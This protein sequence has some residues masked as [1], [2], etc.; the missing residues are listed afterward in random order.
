ME[1][2]E[3]DSETT[4][5]PEN[6][7][8]K[9]GG[10]AQEWLNNYRAGADGEAV[11]ENKKVVQSR[12]V[13]NQGKVRTDGWEAYDPMQWEKSAATGIQHNTDRAP[14]P[15]ME[16][17]AWG[18]AELS[19]FSIAE[20]D[21]HFAALRAEKRRQNVEEIKRRMEEDK[22]R[23]RQL[24]EQELLHEGKAEQEK[25]LEMYSK[26]K[27]SK[28]P[29]FWDKSDPKRFEREGAPAPRGDTDAK[30][31]NLL[32]VGDAERLRIMREANEELE[33]QL[34]DDIPTEHIEGE[35]DDDWEEELGETEMEEQRRML[36]MFEQ[37]NA[38]KK[39]EAEAAK[40]RE[41]EK[42]RNTLLDQ[43]AKLG[44]D[45]TENGG[46]V[47]ATFLGKGKNTKR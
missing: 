16:M 28:T 21:K 39:K 17:I 41:E 4:P 10:K 8:A 7:R 13:E 1:L 38:K 34:F 31:Q 11:F 5:T 20:R 35:E 45:L 40:D 12:E 24:D 26:N 46:D 27:R 23:Q 30:M 47:L 25:L 22:A 43:I 44:E 2:D 19:N 37:T 29:D 33:R 15:T 3:S 9:Q 6:I 32:A 42:R 14:L 18:A 36:M